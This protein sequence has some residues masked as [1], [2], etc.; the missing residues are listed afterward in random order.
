M[1]K[2]A[3][4]RCK[5]SGIFGWSDEELSAGKPPERIR[6]SEWAVKYRVLNKHAA[7]KGAYKSEMVPFLV[8]IMD[9]AQDP[10]IETVVLCKAAQI[11][12]TDA[13]FN[14]MGYFVHQDPCPIM[15][16][17]ADQDTAEYM[18]VERIQPMFRSSE[19]LK[20]L[21]DNERFSKGEMSFINGAYIALGWASSV[22][23]IA[24]RPMK[25][26]IF[27]EIDKPGYNRLT[28]EAD[29]ISLGEERSN[30][31]PDRKLLKLSTPT[32]ENGNIIKELESSDIIY[33]WHVPCP[34]CGQMQPL[35]WS[36]KHCTGFE[37][38]RYWANDGNLHEVGEVVWEGGKKATNRQIIE[39]ARYKCGEC[40]SL[41]T[42]Q[43]KNE[44]V[45][46]GKMIPRKQSNGYDQKLGFH[47]NRIYSLFDGGRLEKLVRDWIKA[48]ADPKQLQGFI[49]SSL[50]EPWRNI[51]IATNTSAI[52]RARC[53]LN[54]Q[55]VP[56][57][58][59]ALTCGIDVQKYGFWFVVR[60]WAKDYTSWLIHYGQ[61]STWED[62]TEL[63]FETSYPV[64]GKEGQRLKIWRACVD[65]GG[66]D[67]GQGVSQTEET[68]WW[69]RHN[70]CGRGC[71]VWGTKGSSGTLA[72]KINVGKP[73]DKTPS[74][75][76]IPGGLQI[77][78]IDTVKLKDVFHYR[79]NQAIEGLPQAAYLHR[80]TDRIYLNHITAEEKRRDRRGVESWHQI[81]KD[82][83]LLDCEIMAHVCADPE[84]PGGG[85][86]LLVK[87]STA[88]EK[89]TDPNRSERK[90]S[91]WF[92]GFD[93]EN[94]FKRGPRG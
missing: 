79:L 40:G 76:P 43:Q 64:E 59:I 34:A 58:A 75:R 56:Q 1:T 81:R 91:N 73:L 24:S 6:I 16:I 12:G 44:A 19:S 11:G 17:L 36:R 26:V 29:P 10:N 50:A 63:L 46:Y 85:I 92:R 87:H 74:G 39:T 70:S 35:R 2:L 5:Q 78:L 9:V 13:L 84:W 37:N 67:Y 51:T 86:N 33:D 31:F 69:L 82:N 89:K 90:Q 4:N 57:E 41:W 55:I 66:G 77:I 48:Q 22:S 42:T 30:T 27:D 61:V 60:A 62:V 14:I 8:P 53:D 72:G 88:R 23:R 52:L 21:V 20:C 49:N 54:P 47:I 15:I 3:K 94:W 71:R 18:S 80:A 25:I 65:T 93:N 28:E 83:H 32:T 7:M 68:Y 45:R 38:G